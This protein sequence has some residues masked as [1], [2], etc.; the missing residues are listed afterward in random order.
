MDISEDIAARTLPTITPKP[1]LGLQTPKTSNF[2][3]ATLSAYPS[4]LSAL[5]PSSLSSS[6]RSPYPGYGEFMKLDHGLETPITPPLAY[7]DFLKT[8]SWSDKRHPDILTPTSAPAST[9]SDTVSPLI[10]IES[11][12]VSADKVEC[13][14]SCSM[15]K[16]PS[17]T[18]SSQETKTRSPDFSTSSTQQDRLQIP[19]PMIRSTSAT[20]LS[21]ST[22]PPNSPMIRRSYH[23]TQG[24]YLQSESSQA[25]G[26]VRQIREVTTRTMV[27]TPR[28]SAAPKGK[29]RK[30][31]REDAASSEEQSQTE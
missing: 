8:K 5:T 4:E 6:A 25:R 23:Y 15:H 9:T 14:C 24:E 26:R 22:R 30:T 19:L 7:M 16:D 3:E 31:D 10:P 17:S 29:R 12:S 11:S 20:R 21:T 28:I 2:P 13:T 1:R 27:Y 18:V